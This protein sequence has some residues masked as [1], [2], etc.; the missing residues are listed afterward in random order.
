VPVSRS[1]MF[2]ALAPA[3]RLG[4]PSRED[5]LAEAASRSARP[6]LLT[7]LQTLPPGRFDDLRAVW[8]QLPDLPV[9]A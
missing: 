4:S 5:L 6:E 9:E 1:E 2:D 7:L 8:A 3:F